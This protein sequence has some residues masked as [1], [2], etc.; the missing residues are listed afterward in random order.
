FGVRPLFKTL[1][2]GGTLGICSEAKGLISLKVKDEAEKI[3]VE[4]VKPGTYEEYT[5]VGEPDKSQYAT[6]NK[7][8]RVEFVATNRFHAIGDVPKY[9]V[10]GVRLISDDVLH[11]IRE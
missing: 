6:I 7:S 10:H 3:R 9:D 4:A 5:L 8:H 2:K 1:T 11:N